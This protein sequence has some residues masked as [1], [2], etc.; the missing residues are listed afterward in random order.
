MK[1]PHFPKVFGWAELDF[2]SRLKLLALF[3]QVGGGITMTAMSAYALWKLA[4]FRAVWPVF[5]LGAMA[6]MLVGIVLT[7]FGALIYKRGKIDFQAGPVRFTVD[8]QGSIPAVMQQ[9]KE[10]TDV[11]RTNGEDPV[12]GLRGAGPAGGGAGRKDP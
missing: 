4:G 5:Y 11:Q 3:F 9:V 10:I 8:D 6:L 2:P 1:W 12:G 7:G